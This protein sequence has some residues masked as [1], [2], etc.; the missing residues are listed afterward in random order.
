M[1]PHIMIG[2]ICYLNNRYVCLFQSKRKA[3]FTGTSQCYNGLY[4]FRISFLRKVRSLAD[5]DLWKTVLEG[6]YLF[7]NFNNKT[8]KGI[9]DSFRY[10]EHAG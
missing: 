8:E 7:G 1:S 9:S 6:V 5:T 3:S 2:C 4:S 10:G